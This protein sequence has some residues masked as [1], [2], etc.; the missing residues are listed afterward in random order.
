MLKIIKLSLMRIS[1]KNLEMMVTRL[2]VTYKKRDV[3]LLY[4]LQQPGEREEIMAYS[5]R[6]C[7]IWLHQL[8]CICEQVLKRW[9]LIMYT[10]RFLWSL[11]LMKIWNWKLMLSFQERATIFV[12]RETSHREENL[13]WCLFPNKC[14]SQNR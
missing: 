8:E 5:F 13:I 7:L 11:I 4:I 12:V 10:I 3:Y 1:I 14:N 2:Q 9:T 6:H